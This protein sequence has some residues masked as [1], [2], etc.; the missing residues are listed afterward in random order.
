MLT[1]PL[2]PLAPTPDSHAISF[3]DRLYHQVHLYLQNL[4]KDLQL[5]G[6]GA[7]TINAGRPPQAVPLVVQANAEALE[8]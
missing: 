6:F 3:R 8:A 2:L 4:L 5:C 1:V 7:R